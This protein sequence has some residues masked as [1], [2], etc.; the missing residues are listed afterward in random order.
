M[1]VSTLNFIVV[2]AIKEHIFENEI[3]KSLNG[4]RWSSYTPLHFACNN[5]HMEAALLLLIVSQCGLADQ[6]ESI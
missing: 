4:L 6:C 1:R 2:A 3:E 5:G